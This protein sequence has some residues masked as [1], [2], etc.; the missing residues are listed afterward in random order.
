MLWQIASQSNGEGH[1]S[2]QTPPQN[3]LDVDAT[4]GVGLLRCTIPSVHTSNALNNN[5]RLKRNPP[6]KW[7]RRR[8]AAEGESTLG[9]SK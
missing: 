4:A 3:E 7:E 2:S 1:R 9:K 8:H 5:D 6:E